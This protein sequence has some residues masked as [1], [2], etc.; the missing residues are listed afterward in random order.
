MR[1]TIIILMSD[2]P[3]LIAEVKVCTLCGLCKTR[4][5]AV[6]GEGPHNAGIMVIGEGP[7]MN[8]DRQG[9][10]FVGSSGQFLTQ[11]LDKAGFK[12]EGVFITNVVKCRPPENRDPLP[13]EIAAC[14]PYLERQ[15]ALL[16]PKV[17]VTVG[18]VSMSRFFPGEKISAI[19]GQARKINGRVVVAMYH[20][21]AAL[22]QPALRTTLEADFAKLKQLIADASQ[23]PNTTIMPLQPT[24]DD[25][26]Q[27][28]LF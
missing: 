19:H 26:G 5:N 13:E 1:P 21:A 12:R 15:I 24:E 20:P 2:L 4:T 7:G 23:Q 17:I 6:P 25:A 8:E 22:H 28:S 3:A 27:M 14:A 9:R 16:N 18:R 11:L 10:P